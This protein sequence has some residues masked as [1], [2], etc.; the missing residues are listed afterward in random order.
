VTDNAQDLPVA[1]IREIRY[2]LNWDIDSKRMLVLILTGYP[3]LWDTLKLRTFE[4]VLQC[5]TLH[6]RLSKL[7]ESQTKEFIINQLHF[8]ISF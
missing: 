8:F 2:L 4:P 3:E 1:T 5:V 7:T 6:Y